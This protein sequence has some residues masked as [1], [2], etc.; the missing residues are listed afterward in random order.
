MT[1]DGLWY[2]WNDLRE[3]L[4][5]L[6]HGLP[7]GCNPY[8]DVSRRLTRT[9]VDVIF[10]VGA[11]RGQSAHSFRRWYPRA[12]IYCFE[13]VKATFDILQRTVR[14]DA[15]VSVHHLAFGATA[16]AQLIALGPDDRMSNV[17]REAS[18]GRAESI[19]V[20]TLDRFCA[21]HEIDH[22][23][24][25]KIDTE[26]S[27]LAVLEG[28]PELLGRGAARIVEVEGGLNPDNSFHV[29]AQALTQ[30]LTAHGYRLFT[31]YEQVLEWPTAD[32]YLRRANFVF[33]SAETVRRNHWTGS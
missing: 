27:D 1:R 4:S 28:A 15:R 9:S 12:R 3:R 6:W 18:D 23:D 17:G 32:A 19:V 20:E 11:N 29:G 26:G 16:G 8:I 2:R 5:L 24:Y 33:V 31:I 25:L 21:Q 30:C 22:I 7:H 14:H 10:D 13:P